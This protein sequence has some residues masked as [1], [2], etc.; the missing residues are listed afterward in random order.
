VCRHDDLGL[1]AEGQIAVNAGVL[2]LS[3]TVFTHEY[4]C[5]S[6]IQTLFQKLLYRRQTGWPPAAVQGVGGI[7]CHSPDGM[8][9]V[10]AVIVAALAD[11][12][13]KD[14]ARIGKRM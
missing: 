3:G 13:A 8:V 11:V 1:A 14:P 5:G 9:A 4:C 12:E 10:L 6:Q 2:R 7:F